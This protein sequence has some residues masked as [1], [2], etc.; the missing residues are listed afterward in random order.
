MSVSPLV[1]AIIP[2]YNREEFTEIAV[3]SVL[4]QTY[5]NIELI[6]IDDGSTDN[7]KQILE[8]YNLKYIFQNNQGVSAARNKG[9]NEAKGEFIAFLDSDDIW[10]KKKIEIQIERLLEKKLKISHTDE[11]WLKNGKHLNPKKKHQKYGGY[12]FDKSLKLCIISPSSVLIHRSVFD[13]VGL[14]DEKMEVCEDYDFWLRSTSHRKGK[15]FFVDF[16]EKKLV[17]KQGG[18]SDQLSQKLWGMDK[19]R[20]YSIEKLLNENILN[21]QEKFLCYK[22]IVRKLEVLVKGFRKHNRAK[23]MQEF[24][25]KL[26]YYKFL[27]E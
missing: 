16:V 13:E 22:E 7:I 12:F 11:K 8:N 19:F 26:E 2:T 10:Q 18:H 20:V 21:K 25:R 3:Q 24:Q 27:M 4:K 17:I 1:S 23:T 14:F 5:R 6:V 15:V 9:I